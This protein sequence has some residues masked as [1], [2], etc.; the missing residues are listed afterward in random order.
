MTRLAIVSDTHIPSR[1]RAISD[2]V[3]AEIE[4]ADRVIHAGDFVSSEALAT[5]RDLADGDLTAVTGNMD[6]GLSLPPTA[7]LEVAGHTVVVTH[8]TG[9]PAGYEDRVRSTAR[10]ATEEPVSIAVAGHTHE[11]L[12]S[13]GDIRI[14]NP[15]S[16]T[17]AAPASEVSMMRATVTRESVDVAVLR[18]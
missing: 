7:T 8:G 18:R 13:P 11:V 15:G 4:A 3:E 6:R 10:D 17:G 1:A 2:W 14:L 9:S 5:I 12:D 16:A